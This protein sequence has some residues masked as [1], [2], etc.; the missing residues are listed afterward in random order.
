[1]YT[2][3]E[4]AA[5]DRIQKIYDR[6]GRNTSSTDPQLMN[7]RVFVGNLAADKMTRQE[8]E[9]LFQ[10]HGKILG[11][12]IHKSYGFVQF[13]NDED[14]KTAVQEMNGQIIHGLRLGELWCVLF[15]NFILF[16]VM[17]KI[18]FGNL[19]DIFKCYLHIL[20]CSG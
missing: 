6:E 10:E 17:T 15:R 9:K 14:A 16:F 2:V 18:S 20:K 12:S 13:A 8:V 5:D 3:S 11:V 7:A 4:M 19:S 1:M